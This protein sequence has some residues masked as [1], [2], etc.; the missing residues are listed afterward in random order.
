MTLSSFNYYI[1]KALD[2]TNDELKKVGKKIKDKNIA[3]FCVNQKNG[4][5]RQKRLWF[6]KE[7][8]LT[9][10]FLINKKIKI[11]D[12]GKINIF[13]V[14]ALIDIFK[15]IGIRERVEFK[16]PNDIFVKKKKIGGVLIETVLSKK[17][18]EQFV[19]G[20]GINHVKKSLDNKYSCI[21]LKDLKN[22]VDP[23]TLFFLISERIS[24]FESK[25]QE[26]DFKLL[27]KNLSGLFFNK[28]NLIT[29]KFKNENTVGKFK[30]INENGELIIF[31]DKHLRKINFGEIVS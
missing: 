16:W 8:D 6:S 13:I 11:N 27:S 30:S 4:R 10:S 5:G 17:F 9:C 2:N 1:Y 20:I 18:I 29:I 31:I 3:L 23:L 22:K 26:I 25:F 21:S 15:N 28:N 14:S 7:G 12:I 19:I 24:Y